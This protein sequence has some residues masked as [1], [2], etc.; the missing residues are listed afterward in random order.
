[1]AQSL[2]DQSVSKL[3]G[4][5]TKEFQVY[6]WQILQSLLY[7]PHVALQ[8]SWHSSPFSLYQAQVE[9]LDVFCFICN[10]VIGNLIV[11]IILSLV[12]VFCFRPS[13]MNAGCTTSLIMLISRSNTMMGLGKTGKELVWCLQRS[14]QEGMNCTNNTVREGHSGLMVCVLSWTLELKGLGLGLGSVICPVHCV[15]LV[16]E[17]LNSLSATP[18]MFWETCQNA[19]QE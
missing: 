16:C 8:L 1:M 3:K 11:R 5:R 4:T 7:F 9:S 17:T 15:L 12:Y 10:F 14:H 6:P 19:G 18:T 13:S 2:F